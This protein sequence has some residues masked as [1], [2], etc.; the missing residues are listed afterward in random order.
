MN[1][2]I[3]AKTSGDETIDSKSVLDRRVKWKEG[4]GGWIGGRILIIIVIW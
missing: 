1:S 4:R 2:C 3:I